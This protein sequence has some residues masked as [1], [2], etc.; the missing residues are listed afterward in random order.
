MKEPIIDDFRE[1]PSH[2]DYVSMLRRFRAMLIDAVLL[3][4]ATMIIE[5]YAE[6]NLSGLFL[7]LFGSMIDFLYKVFLEKQFGQTIGKK[8]VGIAVVREDLGL[9]SWRQAVVRNYYY[10]I[11]AVLSVVYDFVFYISRPGPS[12]IA[13]ED[14]MGFF[15][16]LSI[17]FLI[18]C[19][20]M[21]REVKNQTLHDKWAKTVVVRESFLRK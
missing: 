16:L 6:D 14:I 21:A 2:V 20:M 15:F 19:F 4:I 18:D 1:L 10:V 13:V 3:T 12:A 17:V 5:Y 11:A 8:V 7:L 9:I